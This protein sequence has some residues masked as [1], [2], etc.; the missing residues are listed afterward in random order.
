MVYNLAFSTL[1]LS[2][3]YTI[4]LPLQ[5]WHNAT[6][7]RLYIDS[8]KKKCCP[9]MEDYQFNSWLVA[10]KDVFVFEV[11]WFLMSFTS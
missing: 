11:G 9:I 1:S 3:S 6:K 2:Q 5:Q 8:K 10:L 7:T 4:T